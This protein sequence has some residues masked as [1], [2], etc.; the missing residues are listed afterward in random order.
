[1]SETWF[2]GVGLAESPFAEAE[3]P[4][5]GEVEAPAEAW[6][7]ETVGLPPSWPE[8]EED[9]AHGE[10]PYATEAW[11]P[12]A[13]T[14]ALA[15]A[16]GEAEEAEDGPGSDRF[17]A[18]RLEWPGAPADQLAFMRAVYE[19]HVERSR[20]KGEPFT[21]DLPAGELDV[22]EERHQARADTAGAAR[23]LLTEARATLAA[24][25]LG[26]KV[27]IGIVS[28]YRPASQQFDIW[29]G[30]GR[31]GEGGFPYY[32]ARM[33]QRGRLR[34]G[35]YGPQAVAAM[36]TEIANFIAAPGFS[37]HQDG[38][39]IDFGTGLVG[40]RALG[41]ISERAWFH[42]WLVAR[43]AQGRQNAARHGFHPYDKE[44][45]HWTYQGATGP[46]AA[47]PGRAQAGAASRHEL[48]IE[49]APLLA[50]HRGRPPKGHDLILRWN[51]W[52]VPDVIDVVVHLHGNGKPGMR[53]QEDVK[54]YSGLDL[55]PVGGA[56]GP[57]RSRPTLTVL[58]RGND[59]GEKQKSP[60]YYNQYT[61]PNLLTK[62]GF[63]ELVRYSL[64]RFAA[65]LG[66]ATPKVGRLIL[67]AHS[68]GGLTLLELLKR[69]DPHQVHQVHVFDAL[70]WDATALGDWARAHLQRDRA[71]LA[72]L[73]PAAAR[74]Y[75]TTRGGALRV[76]YKHKRKNSGTRYYSREL[77]KQLAASIG[78]GLEAWYRVEAS[79]C[80][81]FE[82]PRNYGWRVLAD[83][84][85]NVPDAFTE[86]G[87]QP[88]IGAEPFDELEEPEWAAREE[89]GEEE[90]EDLEEELEEAASP[91]ETEDEAG[92]MGTELAPPAPTMESI[93]GEVLEGV[94][95][96][97]SELG[98]LSEDI[99]RVGRQFES[100]PATEAD[101]ADVVSLGK[102]I[103]RLGQ[104][105]R[106]AFSV[107][108]PSPAA[109][110]SVAV[111]EFNF[112]TRLKMPV[113]L[114]NAA[115]NLKAVQWNQRHH[116][117]TSGVDSRNIRT[118]V[119]RYVNLT[120]IATA[121]QNF[122]AANP[123]KPIQLGTPPMDAV[124]VEGIHQ[125]QA[126]CFF[127]TG[128]IDGMAGESTL[129]SL[130]LV[131]RS[132]MNSVDQRNT[133]AHARLGRVDVAGLTSNEFTAD[134]W[135]DHMVNPSFLGWRFLTG[136]TP[137]GAHLSFMRKLRIAERALLAQSKFSGKT[138]V[139]LGKA[140]GFNA[141]SEEHKG[142]RPTV[143]SASMHTYG[144]AVDIKYTGNP[145]VRGADFLAALKR[146]ALLMSGVRITQTTSQRFLHDLGADATRTTAAIFDILA[147]RNRDFRDYLALS[148]NAAGLTAVLQRRR[149][150]GTVGVFAAAT[151][152]IADAAQRWRTDIQNDLRNMRAKA[153][154]FRSGTTRDPLLGFLTLDR[155]LVIALRDTACLAWGA[156][157]IGSGADGSGDMMH[158]D[159]RV[160][161]IGRALAGEG[162]NFQPRSG[163]PC[164][165]CGAPV[166]S[167]EEPEAFEG[168]DFEWERLEEI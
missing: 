145:W 62:D 164:V 96:Q 70:Y 60:P 24:D 117:A 112:L 51:V 31:K 28:A 158:F 57:G 122:N 8:D 127:E 41:F 37:N 3:S 52:S 69:R 48:A 111:P 116:P 77:Y 5:G 58:P 136:G 134:T 15:E 99:E 46:K 64:E 163:H 44:A 18:S 92:V 101:I 91:G 133:G 13:P 150:E 33:L 89:L 76:L 55:T 129:D 17:A 107:G 137:R 25:G 95:G 142:A 53:L 165:A 120:A 143:T 59:T 43:D 159:D 86:P 103:G 32:Y 72:K 39:A 166:A 75:M 78:P 85:A 1:M 121:I 108:P 97:V 34:P 110:V 125:F 141:T 12:W 83:A 79:P 35:D 61:F 152:S 105:I 11:T 82:I 63:D 115:A 160:C 2:E 144:L 162:G 80:G 9:G 90:F 74:E 23:E 149:A 14:E 42:K 6:P 130:G 119:A 167:H 4:F 113:P 16:L 66:G 81:H 146:S 131:K 68:A 155:D 22:I 19:K 139:E 148:A 147:Q 27:R 50:G 88:E 73:A 84:S 45:W 114:L 29:Q 157:D 40:G 47:A 138:P 132:G 20:A 104:G 102:G 67:T 87:M 106:S 30:K 93:A 36:A 21:A 100:A 126:K 38:L 54:P 123:T 49:R 26:D 128:Q 156:V 135:F 154:P 109:D 161:G 10:L 7:A 94:L 124:L 71:E 65:E 98:R 140:L 153:S 118:D 56:A 168:G 151:E